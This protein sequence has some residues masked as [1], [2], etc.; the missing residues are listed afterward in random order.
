MDRCRR[1][2]FRPDMR[3]VHARP[4]PVEPAGCVQLGEQDAVQLV[5]DPCLLPPLQPAPTC[6]PGA[7]PQLRGQELP[8]DVVAEHVQDALQAQPGQL[9]VAALVT[10]SARAA[11]AARSVPTSR[12]PRS[13]ANTH[14][15]T[16]GRIVTLVTAD[17]S[18][19]SRS[20]YEPFT[21]LLSTGDGLASM[22]VD[23]S[24][25]SRIR[26][27]SQADLSRLACRRPS[28]LH[29]HWTFRSLPER[30]LWHR[31]LA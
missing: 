2:S 5:E 15:T 27:S 28:T 18:I 14:P 6:L 10:L 12:R 21:A 24:T 26:S 19:S 22:P 7:E 13:T 4:G 20:W 11:V 17:Q 16:N 30:W 25:G 9:P 8:G 23:V 29:A 3:A 31:L 1:P